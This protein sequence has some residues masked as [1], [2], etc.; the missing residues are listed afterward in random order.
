MI[1]EAQGCHASLL[2]KWAAAYED[3]ECHQDRLWYQGVALV[4]PPE[5]ALRWGAVE[6]NHNLPV[7]GHPGAHKTHQLLH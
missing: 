7:V 2:A 3:L 5:D 1:Q 4:V 6:L